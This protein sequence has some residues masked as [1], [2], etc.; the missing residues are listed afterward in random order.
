MRW[1]WRNKAC[2]LVWWPYLTFTKKNKH[3]LFKY[4]LQYGAAT[5]QEKICSTIK[6]DTK[7][8]T[9]GNQLCVSATNAHRVYLIMS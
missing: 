3:L 6:A 1:R 4:F 5:F 7:K 8:S 2:G 9:T